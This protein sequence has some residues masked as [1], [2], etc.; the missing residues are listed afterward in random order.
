MIEANFSPAK[1]KA[2]LRSNVIVVLLIAVLTLT[3][4]AQAEEGKTKTSTP[5]APPQRLMEA[6]DPGV[7][8]W[9]S[10]NEQQIVAIY[11][12]EQAGRNFGGVIIIGDAAMHPN[13]PDVIAP[14]RRGLPE[15]GW[16]TLSIASPDIVADTKKQG[17]L[18]TQPITAYINA[19]VQLFQS[20]RIQNIAVIGYGLGA[21]LIATYLSQNRSKQVIAFVAISLDGRKIPDTLLSA[22]FLKNISIPILDIY[23]SNDFRRVIQKAHS[24]AN[25][26]SK[27]RNRNEGALAVSTGVL[28]HTSVES[29]NSDI[30]FRQL[31]VAGA[32]HFFT[33]LEPVLVR[34][35]GGWL[36]QHAGVSKSMK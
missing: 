4:T 29:K 1:T 13:W 3:T 32:D 33:G 17:E 22:P 14:L 16:A 21:N 10:V 5:K 9:L 24:R 6:D 20:K 23:G 7:A 31:K 30:T 28:A 26:I 27:A 12:E 36:K 15:A 35:I 8:Q 19:A 34:R 25:S 18:L 2:R 11:T